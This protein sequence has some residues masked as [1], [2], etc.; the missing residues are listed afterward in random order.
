MIPNE[1]LRG[2]FAFNWRPQQPI[3]GLQAGDGIS[4]VDNRI[5]V[6]GVQDIAAGANIT[7]DRTNPHVPIISSSG[8]GGGGTVESVVAGTGIAVDNTDP[9]NPVVSATGG[10]GV[11]GPVEGISVHLSADYTTTIDNEQISGPW[12]HDFSSNFYTSPN[13]DLANGVYTVPADGKYSIKIGGQANTSLSVAVNGASVQSNINE[14]GGIV[15]IDLNLSVG[16]LVTVKSQASSGTMYL[17]L[18]D[19]GFETMIDTYWSMHRIGSGGTINAKSTTFMLAG[20]D[21]TPGSDGEYKYNAGV[22]STFARGAYVCNGPFVI[23]NLYV[24]T[25]N[26]PGGGEIASITVVVDD[27]DTA[28]VAT[29]TG[30]STNAWNTTDQVTVS[31]TQLVGFRLGSSAGTAATIL[32]FSVDFE[33]PVGL[34]NGYSVSA[35]STNIDSDATYYIGPNGSGTPTFAGFMVASTCVFQGMVYSSDTAPGVGESVQINVMQTGGP[36]NLLTVTGSTTYVNQDGFSL[37]INPG[38]VLYFRVVTSAA[39]PNM[40]IRLAMHLG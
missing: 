21:A 4:I 25:D 27:F 35:P 13:F 37:V 31:A 32:S 5:S 39:C 28:L 8:G 22:A 6:S 24:K 26:P 11:S 10:G 30:S 38:D 18:N 15:V 34:G 16:D 17:K 12:A 3:P 29:A 9:A 1:G 7:I 2:S 14:L 33:S 40:N 36:I 19:T 20:C 23:K